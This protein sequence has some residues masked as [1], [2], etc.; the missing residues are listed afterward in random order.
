VQ[1]QKRQESVVGKITSEV[2]F[3]MF[4]FLIRA[5]AQLD[6]VFAGKIFRQSIII[7]HRGDKMHMGIT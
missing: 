6:R 1:H 4:Y 2:F 7:Q 5:P 3:K